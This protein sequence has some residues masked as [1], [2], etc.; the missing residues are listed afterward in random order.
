MPNSVSSALQITIIDMAI[1]FA[2]LYIIALVINGIRI[3]IMKM[4]SRGGNDNTNIP[5]NTAGTAVSPKNNDE[6]S[7]KTNNDSENAADQENTGQ[8]ETPGHGKNGDTGSYRNPKPAS[9]DTGIFAA[10]ISA[11]VT[12]YMTDEFAKEPAFTFRARN[13]TAAAY[14]GDRWVDIGRL[15]QLNRWP[16][17]PAR[18]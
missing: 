10:V 11:A 3:A 6:P 1:V 12:S 2:V 7:V 8:G 14:A 17:R 15:N 9:R 4:G 5:N 18:W 16:R 13:E